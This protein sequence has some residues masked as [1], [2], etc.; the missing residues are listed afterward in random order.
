MNVS[1]VVLKNGRLCLTY[2]EKFPFQIIE[3]NINVNTFEA[4]LVFESE[5][6]EPVLLDYPV[7]YNLMP[8]M[9]EKEAIYTC[10][11]DAKTS[12][13]MVEVPISFAKE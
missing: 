12:S 10:Y 3:L 7:D 8:A 5:E 4:S 11:S 13:P 9:L 6:F 1:I 2:D